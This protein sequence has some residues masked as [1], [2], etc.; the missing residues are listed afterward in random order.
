MALMSSQR[1]YRVKQ[2]ATL[3]GVSVRALHHYDA[4]GLLVPAKRSNAGYRLYTDDDL[5]RL[6]QILIGRE[7][8]LGLEEIRRSL[9]DPAY[10]RRQALLEQRS[11]LR[12]RAEA[13][14]TMIRAIDAALAVLGGAA[15]EAKEGSEVDMK[16]I[17]DGFDPGEHEEEARQRWGGTEAYKVSMQR[18]KAYTEEDWRR[19]RAE[20][21]A[22][23]S[24]AFAALQAGKRPEDPDAIAVAERHRESIDKWFYPCTRQMHLGLAELYEADARFAQSIDKH[25]EGLAPFLIAAIRANA[26]RG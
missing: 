5:L 24:D 18:T 26:A 2:V 16:K 10:D 1:T 21:E 4:V 9:D 25:G 6:Q 12:R 15:A 13:A 22:I 3:S 8:G 11:A 17:F 19:M 20:Q 7:L 23:Y 14:G